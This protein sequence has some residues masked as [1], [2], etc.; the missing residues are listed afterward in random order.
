MLEFV[1]IILAGLVGDLV[2]LV[3]GVSTKIIRKRLDMHLCRER[4]PGLRIVRIEVAKN[5]LEVVQV[6]HKVVKNF[7]VQDL[8]FAPGNSFQTRECARMGM[9]TFHRSAEYHHSRG[10][11]FHR[12]AAPSFS[13]R[14]KLRKR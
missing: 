9:L 14:L 13:T 5:G 10:S 6:Y 12:A 8:L 3:A 11:R 7:L 2:E 1:A 4:F